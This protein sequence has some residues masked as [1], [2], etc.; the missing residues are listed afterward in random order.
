V[1]ETPRI[2]DDGEPMTGINAHTGLP[3]PLTNK[4]LATFWD[5]T[6]HQIQVIISLHAAITSTEIGD[7]GDAQA[8]LEEARN[9]GSDVAINILGPEAT[10]DMTEKISHL[11]AAL[12]KRAAV[13]RAAGE[14]PVI[15]VDGEDEYDSE[16]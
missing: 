3:E 15:D 12:N 8:A 14:L 6:T 5:L 7:V 2:G 1:I 16:V 9:A 4:R 11:I 10:L 13:R